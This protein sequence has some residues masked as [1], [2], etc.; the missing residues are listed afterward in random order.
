MG[1]PAVRR[2]AA[3]RPADHCLLHDDCKRPRLPAGAEVE[4]QGVGGADQ[5]ALGVRPPQP[6]HSVARVSGRATV[7]LS[8]TN[9]AGNRANSGTAPGSAVTTARP[10][11]GPA[12]GRG[13]AEALVERL[14]ADRRADPGGGTGQLAKG[15]RGWRRKPKT[16]V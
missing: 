12:A 15:A 7:V 5:T 2:H 16:S 9:T 11:R 10:R 8:W 1:L 4:G 13:L 14:G 3:R 6:A